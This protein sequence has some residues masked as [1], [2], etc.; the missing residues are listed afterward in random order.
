M[1]VNED[2]QNITI[3]LPRLQVEYLDKVA[4]E[5]DLSRSQVM[6]MII[7][8]YRAKIDKSQDS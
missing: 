5:S 4:L 2:S 7:R 8:E 1:P 6:R 3:V